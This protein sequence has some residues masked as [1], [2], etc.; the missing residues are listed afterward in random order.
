MDVE[1]FVRACGSILPGDRLAR[2]AR[3]APLTT[4]R[5]GGPADV[6]VDVRSAS[7][8]SGVLQAAAQAQVP[9]LVIGGGSNLLVADAGVRGAV[10]RLADDDLPTRNP[11]RDNPVPGNPMWGSAGRSTPGRDTTTPGIGADDAYGPVRGEREPE[12]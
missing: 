6:L 4:F 9:V 5:V 10:L 7:E 8:L 3:L 12:R 11:V 2:H 1:G